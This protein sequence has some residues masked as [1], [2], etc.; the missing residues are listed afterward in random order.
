MKLA[1]TLER[2]KRLKGPI[3]AIAG[4]GAVLSGLVGW[5]TT[6]RVVAGPSTPAPATVA[7][8]ASA[9][10]AGPLSVL[11]LPFANQTGDDAKG[12]I[13][14]GLTSAIS[15]DLTRMREAY[16]V[17]A[18]TAF[19]YKGKS[20]TVQQVGA[21]AGV[22]FVMQGHVLA[23]GDVL[24]V[25]I[26][27]TDAKAG[28]QLW[29]ETFEGQITQLFALQD[30][31]TTRTRNS[32]G[33]EMV[34]AA[35]KDSQK[36]AGNASAVDLVLQASALDLLPPSLDSFTKMRALFQQALAKDADNVDATA[37]LAI[38]LGLACDFFP[39]QCTSAQRQADQQ[40]MAALVRKLK[41]MDPD[42]LKA[43]TAMTLHAYNQRDFE[44]F[45]QNSQHAY[46]LSPTSQWSL[47]S[48]GAAHMLAGE[49]DKAVPLLMKSLEIDPKHPR[50]PTLI[51]LGQV[52]LMLGR[53]AQALQWFSKAKQ[54]VPDSPDVYAE[55][56]LAHAMLGDPA[57]AQAA[58]AE[59]KRLAPNYGLRNLDAPFPSSPQA[60]KDIWA[61]KI[62][63][64]ARLAGL[65]GA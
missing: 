3:A 55:L 34:L 15:A 49:L 44:A 48:L 36:R 6:Y 45:M 62:V 59:L 10:D 20:L 17:P 19:T 26:Q 37:G 2:I 57:Q 13:A 51:T 64:A 24:R 33:R 14:D 7:A 23:S 32:I 46:A 61:N 40:Q 21:D 18:S 25:S 47:H 52:E 42:N 54:L 22:R 63:P 65:P 50:H 28:R 12:Y 30:Q 38:L 5:Y 39:L 53:P 16:V 29:N 43:V 1:A 56:A 11:V 27:L 4:V 58:V 8:P 60:Y 41:A 35:A 31:V 9:A